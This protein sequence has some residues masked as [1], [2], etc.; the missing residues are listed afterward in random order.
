LVAAALLILTALRLEGQPWL[1]LAAVLMGLLAILAFGGLAKEVWPLIAVCV[2][3]CVCGA[4]R[5]SQYATF[6]GTLGQVHEI[7]NRPLSFSKAQPTLSPSDLQDYLRRGGLDEFGVDVNS[8]NRLNEILEG[9]KRPVPTIESLNLPKGLTPRS[10]IQPDAGSQTPDA[11]R[12]F[13]SQLLELLNNDAQAKPLG[14]V[15]DPTDIQ[16]ESS[17]ANPEDQERILESRLFDL[18]ADNQT[19]P[20][21]SQPAVPTDDV[22]KSESAREIVEHDTSADQANGE[23]RHATK[24]EERE[25]TP[26]SHVMEDPKT[27]IM[28]QELC[29]AASLGFWV[30]ISVMAS[31]AL[32]GKEGS[33]RTDA[34]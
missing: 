9:L 25:S 18:G 23:H 30:T 24:T 21:D 34:E 8:T 10:L 17:Q 26:D 3:L 27:R 22:P 28:T 31:W 1:L 14:E 2:A 5:L 11:N 7:V 4:T 16:S 19:T 20:H 13:S 12:S 6:A 15:I 32:L 33:S 29:L